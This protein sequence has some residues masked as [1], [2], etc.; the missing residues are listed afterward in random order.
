MVVAAVGPIVAVLG[1]LSVDVRLGAKSQSLLL[2]LVLLLSMPVL[3][4]SNVVIAVV[5]GAT[6]FR[7]PATLWLSAVIVFLVLHSSI[8]TLGVNRPRRPRSRIEDG[9]AWH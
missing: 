4:S 7:V 1:L 9:V 6:Q 5:V 8:T 3:F 2:I